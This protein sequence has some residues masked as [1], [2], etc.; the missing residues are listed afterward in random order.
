M[1]K[2]LGVVVGAILLTIIGTAAWAERAYVTDSFEVTLRTGPSSGNKIIAM[3]RS[4]QPLEVLEVEGDWSH[5]NL[6]KGGQPVQEGWILSRYLV[7]RL[8]WELQ[9][10]S[11][12]E[13]NASLKERL[14]RLE[15]EIGQIQRINKE[16]A[17]KLESSNESLKKTADQYNSL[18]KGAASYLELKRDYEAAKSAL[19]TAEEKVRKLSEEN[20]ILN[21]S[22]RNKWFATGAL[23]LL[24]G[25]MIGVVVGSRQKK[26]RSSLY[27]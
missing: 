22:Q 6:L 21:S 12:S 17:T 25:L 8:P 3:P 1:K 19:V 18:K 26:R 15:E 27:S 9:T 23:V 5:V 4:G 2:V 11:L 16:L 20:E 24:C 7:R 10:K 13:E 14:A